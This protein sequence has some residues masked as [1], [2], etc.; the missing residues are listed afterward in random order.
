M[1]D[2]LTAEIERLKQIIKCRD[3]SIKRYKTE[4]KHNK[5]LANKKITAENDKLKARA[6]ELTGEVEK[7]QQ[8]NRCS[9][10]LYLKALE[11]MAEANDKAIEARQALKRLDMT[12]ALWRKALIKNEELR[13]E[14]TALIETLAALRTRTHGFKVYVSCKLEFKEET[15]YYEYTRECTEHGHMTTPVVVLKA[16]HFHDILN[17]RD[18]LIQRQ[19]TQGARE[20]KLKRLTSKQKNIIKGQTNK[21]KRETEKLNH[22]LHKELNEWKAKYHHTQRKYAEFKKTFAQQIEKSKHTQK[23]IETYEQYYENIQLLADYATLDN[24]INNL[25]YIRTGKKR[26]YH[27]TPPV[28]N[29]IHTLKQIENIDKH[30]METFNM[31]LNEF[32]RLFTDLKNTRNKI[33]HPP[34]TGDNTEGITDILQRVEYYYDIKNE[35]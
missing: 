14:N 5:E 8:L 3:A 15:D 23:L 20:D 35:Q 9:G 25:C 29:N 33:A 34:P 17:K 30:I 2:K 11:S 18:M 21:Y 13:E 24:Y 22:T 7:L 10:E 26:N 6:A 1:M 19:R 4:R 12:R 27:S 28:Y 31:E 16:S 32:I